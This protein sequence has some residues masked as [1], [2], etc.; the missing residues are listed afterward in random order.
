M[1]LLRC[2][3]RFRHRCRALLLLHLHKWSHRQLARF[4]RRHTGR[5]Q[6]ESAITCSSFFDALMG[7]VGEAMIRPV[8]LPL[9]P[10]CPTEAGITS[11]LS[12]EY[13]S[14]FFNERLEWISW[15]NQSC[16]ICVTPSSLNHRKIWSSRYY[17]PVEWEIWMLRRIRLCGS[18]VY[19]GEINWSYY[20][21]SHISQLVAIESAQVSLYD[22]RSSAFSISGALRDGFDEMSHLLNL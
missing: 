7:E 10:K 21:H 1:C 3:S 2:S 15:N 22:R 19:L 4:N 5:L 6:S 11:L 12:N 14:A 16:R 17:S 9:R 13:K 20:R 8:K 18:Y